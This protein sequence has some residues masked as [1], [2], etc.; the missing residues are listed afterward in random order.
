V[1]SLTFCKDL[2]AW[3]QCPGFARNIF[4]KLDS[5]NLVRS[6][7]KREVFHVCLTIF[8]S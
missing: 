1:F 4:G 7:S 8:N 5:S 6:V 2:K 3:T